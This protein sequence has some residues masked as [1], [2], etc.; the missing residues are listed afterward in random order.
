VIRNVIFDLG[1]VLIDFDFDLAIRKL[2]QH[3]QVDP[4]RLFALFRDTQLARKWDSGALSGDEFHAAIQKTLGIDLPLTTLVPIW[5]EIF[6]EKPEMVRLYHN[7]AAHFPAL[8]LSNTN[9]WH[10]EYL[11]THYPWLGQKGH[12]IASCQAKRMKPDQELFQQALDLL[13]AQ[14]QETLYVDDIPEFVESACLMGIQGI[15]FKDYASLL[16]ELQKRSF[17]HPFQKIIQS[18]WP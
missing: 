3:H 15:V 2:V 5:N 11:K 13:G 18:Q 1:K 12:F 10:A 17:A 16:D 4:L 9:P 8:V 6:S 7:L 14:A